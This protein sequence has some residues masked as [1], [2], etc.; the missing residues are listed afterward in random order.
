MSS[1][2][3]LYLFT[4]PLIV[5]TLF[6][7]KKR[8]IIAIAL[9][10]YLVNFI[11]IVLFEKYSNTT[12]ITL[13]KQEL[14]VFYFTN[15][16]FSFIILTSLSIYFLI[17]NT[18]INQLLI[19][20][21]E[22]LVIKQQQLETENKIR[23][24]A[25]EKAT[26]SLKEHEILLSEIHH[27]VKNNLAIVNGLLE[28]QSTYVDD[29]KTLQALKKNKNRVKSIALLH[30]KLY[31]NETLKDVNLKDYINELTH[32]IKQ[33][34]ASHNKEIKCNTPIDN[35]NMELSKAMPFALLLNEL[36]SNSYKYAFINKDQGTIEINLKKQSAHYIFEYTDNGIGFDFDTELSKDS[37][38]LNLI[39]SFSEQLNG[40]FQ[41]IKKED[42]M[43]FFLK[44]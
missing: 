22:E 8:H 16:L 42:E 20:K 28:L 30:E 43:Q 12:F 11:I 36:M 32:F 15:F 27:R 3:H 25:Q 18:R 37:L 41:Y 6:D 26:D 1:G 31:D 10:S 39:E 7:T 38:G 35:I 23:K 9:M 34:C 24:S 29:K 44:F 33:S 2:I 19:L 21:N 5:L 14:D 4:S 40:T 13:R 17:N